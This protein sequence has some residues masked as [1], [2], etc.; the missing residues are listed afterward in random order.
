MGFASPYCRDT[1][2]AVGTLILDCP[3]GLISKIVN[4][5]LSPKDAWIMDPCMPNSD[6]HSCDDAVHWQLTNDTI[7]ESCLGQQTCT[8][9]VRDFVDKNPNLPDCNDITS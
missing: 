8:L 7:T 2:L 5:G 9:N 1:S 3:S 6:I 4:F